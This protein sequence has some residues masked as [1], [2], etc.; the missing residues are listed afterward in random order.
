MVGVPVTF[1]TVKGGGHG[2]RNATAD[3][4]RRSFFEKH[5]KRAK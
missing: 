3:E 5:V 1:Y 4:M 2:F